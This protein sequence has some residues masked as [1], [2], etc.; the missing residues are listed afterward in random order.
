MAD[1]EIDRS[2]SH[3]CSYVWLNN[4]KSKKIFLMA[5]QFIFRTK[6]RS[7][8]GKLKLKFWSIVG[9]AIEITMN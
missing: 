3:C 2:T 8:F 4:L 5:Q 6:H 7:K 1:K 9:F